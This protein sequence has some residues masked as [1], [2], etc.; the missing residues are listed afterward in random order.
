MYL[1]R[2][3]GIK[4][5]LAESA[6]VQDKR[7]HVQQVFLKIVNRGELLITALAHVLG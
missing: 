7:V 4:D 2:H 3:L 5:L 6:V 1:N